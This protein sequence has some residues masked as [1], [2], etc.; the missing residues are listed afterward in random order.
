LRIE[1]VD[2]GEQLAERSCAVI[3]QALA[4]LRGG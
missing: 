1:P 3:E 2:I 4:F